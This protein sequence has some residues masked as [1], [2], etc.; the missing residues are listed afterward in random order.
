MN[1]DLE[2]IVSSNPKTINNWADLLWKALTFLKRK[3]LTSKENRF[4]IILKIYDCI[5]NQHIEYTELFL[6]LAKNVEK[7]TA[8]AQRLKRVIDEPDQAPATSD[9]ITTDIEAAKRTFFKK[10]EEGWI[11]RKLIKFE[12]NAQLEACRDKWEQ[13]FLYLCLLYYANLDEYEI[14]QFEN[15]IVLETMI[16]STLE[17]SAVHTW[18]SPSYAL[19]DEIA[20]KND[21]DEILKCTKSAV[22]RL[23]RRYF[24]IVKSYQR[25]RYEWAT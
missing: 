13:Q 2:D 20:E 10:R 17:D 9:Q 1:V 11:E 8:N 3:D 12:V 5:Q 23:N 16:E 18:N 22:D 4:K 14:A 6:S 21:P 15:Q 7:H 24:G 19:A 25:L